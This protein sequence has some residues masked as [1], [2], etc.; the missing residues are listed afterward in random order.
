MRDSVLLTPTEWKL[1]ECL[2]ASSPR[3]GRQ[4]AEYMKKS[5]LWSRSTTL[6]MLRR[7]TEKGAV[8]SGEENGVL[9]YS[10]LIK[11]EEAAVRETDDF[12][13]RVYHGSVSLLV[14]SMTR[15]QA[16]PQEEI[17]QLY[18]LLQQLEDQKGAD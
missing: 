5:A 7:M 6:T 16:L 12:I 15:R 2:W 8:K 11:R 4:A 1:M 14:S 3:T 9:C 18:A 13:D 10:P 17:D